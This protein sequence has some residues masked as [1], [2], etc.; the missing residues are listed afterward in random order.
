MAVG[1]DRIRQHITTLAQRE[2]SDYAV[3]AVALQSVTWPD[4]GHDRRHLDAQGWFQRYMHLRAPAPQI[5][6]RS[7][8]C[9]TGRCLICN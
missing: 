3:L 8:G 9:A 6:G 5:D 7:C 4:G 1:G 2:P